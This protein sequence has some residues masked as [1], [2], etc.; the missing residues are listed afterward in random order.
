MKY[1]KKPVVI[2]AIQFSSEV[3]IAEKIINWALPRVVYSAM[4]GLVIPTLEGP[5][6]AT[7]GDWIIKGIAGEVYPCKPEIFEATYEVAERPHLK[8]SSS[9]K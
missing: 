3:G 7:R 9:K 2:E 8:Q 4:K 5:M 6:L 1:R